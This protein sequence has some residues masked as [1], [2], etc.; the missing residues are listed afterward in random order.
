MPPE[1]HKYHGGVDSRHDVLPKLRVKADKH[2]ISTVGGEIMEYIMRLMK[3]MKVERVYGKKILTWTGS[4]GKKGKSNKTIDHDWLFLLFAL[5]KLNLDHWT[6]VPFWID[7]EP[8]TYTVM[9]ANTLGTSF[10]FPPEV[11]NPSQSDVEGGGEVEVD[12]GED[13]SGASGEDTEDD[14]PPPEDHDES[15]LRMAQAAGHRKLADNLQHKVAVKKRR[16]GVNYPPPPHHYQPDQ[17]D[18]SYGYNQPQPPQYYSQSAHTPVAE[19]PPPGLNTNQFQN[20]FNPLELIT[21][22]PQ[23]IGSAMPLISKFL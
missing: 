8:G 7:P 5:D 21:A 11:P 1:F 2:S 23:L 16:L 18:Y 15:S 4:K 20:S 14:T 10:N 3:H 17:Y 12:K 19:R 6:W 22:I 13:P 9:L